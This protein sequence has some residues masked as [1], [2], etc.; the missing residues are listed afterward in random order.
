MLR[1]IERGEGGIRTRI[2]VRVSDPK[3]D[4]STNSATS[5]TGQ[6]IVKAMSFFVG[7]VAIQTLQTFT[8]VFPKIPHSFPTDSPS[9][10]FFTN[11]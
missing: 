7:K 4:A 2:P 6:D 8:G 5:P 1:Y 10:T 9:H 11:S 3:S